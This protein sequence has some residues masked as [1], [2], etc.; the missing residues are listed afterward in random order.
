MVMN[1]YGWVWAVTDGM[2]GHGWLRMVL[3]VHVG[4][5]GSVRDGFGWFLMVMDGD[6]LLWM[7][8]GDFR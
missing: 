8:T 5:G 1:G 6:G 3:G 4:S 2:D 7:V